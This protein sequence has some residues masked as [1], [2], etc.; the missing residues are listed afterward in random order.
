MLKKNY[1]IISIQF[2]ILIY[3]FIILAD[4]AGI[5]TFSL[6]VL[7]I[8]KFIACVSLVVNLMCFF[9][10]LLSYSSTGKRADKKL[11]GKRGFVLF[12]TIFFAVMSLVLFISGSIQDGFVLLF[13]FILGLVFVFRGKIPDWYIEFTQKYNFYTGGVIT[14]DNDPSNISPTV[15]MPILLGSILIAI[16]TYFIFL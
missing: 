9:Y 7:R 14:K 5:H 13:G 15:Y 1:I 4:K 10:Y 6:S 2:P 12:L 11:V 3:S 16:L 8:S